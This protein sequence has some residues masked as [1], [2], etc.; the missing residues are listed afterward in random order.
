MAREFKLCIRRDSSLV[1][2]LFLHDDGKTMEQEVYAAAHI[3]EGIEVTDMLSIAAAYYRKIVADVYEVTRLLPIDFPREYNI[4]M[5]RGGGLFRA[6]KWH[7]DN[8][9]EATILE[10]NVDLDDFQ[11]NNKLN[12]LVSITMR[13]WGFDKFELTRV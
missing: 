2:E 12:K 1:Y 11:E 9:F 13:F 10:S 8:T 6:Y 7:E 3:N 4:E 5:K